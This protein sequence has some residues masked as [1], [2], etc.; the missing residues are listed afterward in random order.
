MIPENP[1]GVQ[2]DTWGIEHDEP[3]CCAVWFKYECGDGDERNRRKGEHQFQDECRTY[4]HVFLAYV[5]GFFPY[6]DVVKPE[7]CQDLEYGD[8]AHYVVHQPVL[9]FSKI[10]RHENTDDKYSQ[11]IDA[12]TQH[13]PEYIREHFPLSVG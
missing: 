7:V 8:I 4:Q 11:Q 12:F 9:L 2:D 5:F 3:L 1:C 6:L 10:A 13:C